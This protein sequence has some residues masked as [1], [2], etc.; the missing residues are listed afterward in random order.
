MTPWK[1]PPIIKIYEALGAIGDRRIEMDGDTAKVWA[2]TRD[3]YYDVR[4]DADAQAIMTNDNGSYWQGYLGYPGVAYLL[5]RDVVHYD[6][7]MAEWLRGFDWKEIATRLKND[8]TK[9]ESE[10]RAEMEKR[11]GVEL[12]RFDEQL[13]DIA[14]QL[15]SLELVKLGSRVRPPKGD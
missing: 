8:W 5:V 4:Y 14:R 7:R 15:K 12:A 11:E 9:V 1:Q 10:V 2:S 6:K 13:A 3:K